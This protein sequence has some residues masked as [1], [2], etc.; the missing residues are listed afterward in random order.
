MV[1]CLCVRHASFTCVTCPILMCDMTHSVY[2]LALPSSSSHGC[3]FMCATCLVHTCHVTIQLFQ[4]V[5]LN[6]VSKCVLEH[7]L[8]T[9]TIQSMM[10]TRN[11]QE[12]SGT[13]SVLRLGD[14]RGYADRNNR[15]FVG[16]FRRFG[17][18]LAAA[19]A[20]NLAVVTAV[21][22]PAAARTAAV[23][24]SAA[25]ADVVVAKSRIYIYTYIYIYIYM[26]I[27]IH[28][29]IYI[30]MYIYIYIYIYMYLCYAPP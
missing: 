30:H 10:L 2:P 8:P 25:A 20:S 26:Y 28:T 11:D 27:C 23:T 21:T 1:V 24:A 19:A 5:S 9:Q 7:Q 15:R 4:G 12:S 16:H 22:A 17:C 3:V 18:R 13:L 6:T 14:R 29:Y